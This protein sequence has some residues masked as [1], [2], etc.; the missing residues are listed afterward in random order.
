MISAR[1]T[2]SFWRVTSKS[3]AFRKYSMRLP[4]KQ[5]K[6]VNFSLL[7]SLD[8][9]VPRPS[10]CTQRIRD[11]TI[12]MKTIISMAG[13]STPVVSMSTVT[14]ILG[15]GRLR[16]WRIF[17]RGRSTVGLPVIFITKSSPLPKTSLQVRTTSSAWETWGRSLTAKISILGNRLC[18]ASCWSVYFLMAVRIFLV[19]SGAVIFCSISVALNSRSSSSESS[20]SE[21]VST[22]T[23][24]TISP[25]LR[26]AP[27]I[28]MSDVI[29]TA[30]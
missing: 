26:N 3:V 25:S 16:N 23:S 18:F 29:L 21:P 19:L 28:W 1:E 22:S 12:R 27:L 20:C 11:F 6:M 9:R 30:S 2:V 7:I 8:S 13:I 4:S 17:C 15:S 14:T 24:P 10:I 5:S